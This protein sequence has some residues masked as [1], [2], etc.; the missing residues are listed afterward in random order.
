MNRRDVTGAGR[1]GVLLSNLV[2]LQMLVYQQ[3]A[4][5]A[6]H[7]I[8]ARRRQDHTRSSLEGKEAGRRARRSHKSSGGSSRAALL[9][10]LQ[11]ELQEQSAVLLRRLVV[12]ECSLM[13]ATAQQVVM[14]L[15]SARAPGQG[16]ESKEACRVG[17]EAL[18]NLGGRLAG[19][20]VLMALR[21]CVAGY[22]VRALDAALLDAML[23]FGLMANFESALECKHLLTSLER[24]AH[25][26]APELGFV[27]GEAPAAAA[28][29]EGGGGRV[30][31]AAELALP[32]TRQVEGEACCEREQERG[33]RAMRAPF[34]G[35]R[36]RRGVGGQEV[37]LE[38]RRVEGVDSGLMVA[39]RLGHMLM[40]VPT[41]LCWGTRLCL[42]LCC[43]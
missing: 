20:G 30:M 22:A 1:A 2:L 5:A 38:A 26:L 40:L 18:G 42:C 4:V 14:T 21:R 12:H 9:T 34:V 28:A 7:D 25:K 37:V 8:M 13:Q 36:R 16:Q 27:A 43:G 10:D 17:E 41:C 35:G 15:V 19:E 29:G 24:C 6:H 23:R 11:L 32:L 31:A 39:L 3:A 33:G